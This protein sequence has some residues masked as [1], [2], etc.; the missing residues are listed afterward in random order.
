MRKKL[1]EK[2]EKQET[3]DICFVHQLDC[4]QDVKGFFLSFD[5]KA[6]IH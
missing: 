1:E 6:D 2:K 3:I 5:V 4:T